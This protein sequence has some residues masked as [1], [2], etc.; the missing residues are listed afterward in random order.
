MDNQATYEQ[1]VRTFKM[2]DLQGC[3]ERHHILPRSLGGGDDPSNIVRLTP[4]AHFVAHRL[5]ARIHGG[6]MWAALAYMSRGNTKS[7]R[8][9]NVTSRTYDLIARKDAEWRSDYYTKN[10]P[11]RGKTHSLEASA[12]MRGPRPSI[13][14]K[15]HPRYGKK[16]NEVGYIISSVRSYNPRP[17]TVDLTVRNRIDRDLV[18][19]CDALKALN[20]RY[21]KRVSGVAGAYDTRGDKNPNFGNGAKITGDKNPMFGKSQSDATRAKISEKAKRKAECP[22]CGKI[23]SVSNMKR[24]HFDSCKH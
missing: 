1:L 2:R 4:K 23:G 6:K 24:W 5:L 15:N 18:E 16:N 22:N 11:F 10:N 12:K 13:A 19:T 7:A 17:F 3:A 14:G 21:R 9:V 8:G 20:T